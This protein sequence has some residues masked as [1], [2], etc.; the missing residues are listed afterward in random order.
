MNFVSD[1]FCIYLAIVL[2]G[3]YLLPMRFR[4]PWL[5]VASYVFYASWNPLFIGLILSTTTADYVLSK[6]IEKHRQS[7]SVKSLCLILGILI[8][9][10]VLIYFKYANFL[11]ETGVFVT[12]RLHLKTS[13]G[14]LAEIVL[15]LGISFYTFEAIGY[16]IDVYRG[17]SAAR[18]FLTYNFY[19]MYFPHLIS[20]PIVRFGEIVD[21]YQNQLVLPSIDQILKGIE[22]LILG[23][24]FKVLI[25]NQV[26]VF[27]EPCFEHVHD[28]TAI[29]AFIGALAFT[30]QIYF[31]FMGY[32]HIARGV[33]LFFNIELP[34][35]FDHPFNSS[36]ISEYWRRWHITLSRWFR[37]YLFIPL[38]G[39]RQGIFRTCLNLST[40]MVVC[41]VWHGAAITFVVFGALHGAYLVVHRVWQKLRKICRFE[42]AG[43]LL[44]T[45]LTTLLTFL[46]VNIAFVFFRAHTISDANIVIAK[47]FRINS[48]MSHLHG[49]CNVNNFTSVSTILFMLVACFAG[50][51]VV[52]VADKV[53][54]SSPYW[55]RTSFACWLCAAIW[56][57]AADSYKP[58]IYFQF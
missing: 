7:R 57:G 4:M 54:T 40:V 16:L 35:N 33:S 24:A 42:P 48:I 1:Q 47:M 20:G 11:L 15:P 22:L 51:F 46:S 14:H 52:R 12:D 10:A 37:D 29:G 45:T 55:L 53:F 30:T 25:A 39:S 18:N 13:F 44:Y 50:P 2:I 28:A 43:N 19:I 5:L 36:N 17:R 23:L 34:L 31:D 8:N 21:Q 27:V 49:E 56:I 32:T 58:F 3:F 38:G 9:L 26:A 6:V 41:G